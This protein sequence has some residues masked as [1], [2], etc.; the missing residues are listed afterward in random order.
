MKKIEMGWIT[1]VLQIAAIVG[2][3]IIQGIAAHSAVNMAKAQLN[4]QRSLSEQEKLQL[5]QLLHNNFTKV[6]IE[7]FLVSI[8]LAETMPLP[9][10]IPDEKPKENYWIYLAV[11]IGVLVITGRK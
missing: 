2:P 10:E 4:L 8:N 6:S 9:N 5:A 7:D 11:F 3:Y 1:V